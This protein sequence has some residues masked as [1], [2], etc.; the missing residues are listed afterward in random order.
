MRKML[1]FQA[2]K[3][4]NRIL[5]RTKLKKDHSRPEK[6]RNSALET[7]FFLSAGQIGRVNLQ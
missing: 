7:H 5:E 3:V 1:A 6:F 4:G 2:K